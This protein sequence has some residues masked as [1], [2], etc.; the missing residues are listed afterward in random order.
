MALNLEKQLR[1]VGIN[2]EYES[3]GLTCG[4]MAHITTIRYQVDA[5]HSLLIL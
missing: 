3:T 5:V 4:S 1:F 2:A